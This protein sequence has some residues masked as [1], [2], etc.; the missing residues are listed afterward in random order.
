M[1]RIS[2]IVLIVC[3]V[4]AALYFFT[5]NYIVSSLAR[6]M[7]EKVEEKYGF[8]ITFSEVRMTGLAGVEV[9]Q[10][11]IHPP[12]GDTLLTIDSMYVRPSIP[13]I[14]L[15]RVKLTEVNIS[16]MLLHFSGHDSLVNYKPKKTTGPGEEETNTGG[17]T[18][19]AR[20]L[21]SLSRKVFS[22]SP[23]K[24]LLR[25]VNIRVDQDSIHENLLIPYYESDGDSL[26]GTLVDR[27]NDMTWKMNGT[28]SQ[29][30]ETFSIWIMP[31]ERKAT[32]FPLVRDLTGGY[33]TFDTLEFQLH[34]NEYGDG[35][36]R[37]SGY[38]QAKNLQVLHRRLSGD[39]IRIRNLQFDCHA[40]IGPHSLQL[41]SAT[42]LTLN[43]LPLNI[44][45]KLDKEM[46]PVV[47]LQL[48]THARPADDFFTS[49]PEGIFTE[50]QGV[51]ADGNLDFSLLYH[52]D[53][54]DPDKLVFDV[55]MKKEKFK[56]KKLG[57]NSLVKMNS[58][59]EHTVFEY[60]HPVKT[61]RVGPSDPGFV[62]IAEV[63]PFLKYAILTSEDGNFFYHNGFNEEAFR[64]SIAANFKAGRFVRGGSTISM[65]LVKNVYLSRNKTVARKVEEALLVWLIESNRLVTKERM[66]EVY[67]NII[68]LGPMV[69]GV[70]D[71][72][73]F[74]FNKTPSEVSLA[75]SIFLASLLPH[76]KWFKYSF[77]TTGAF[78]P[79]L[80]D[81]YRVVSNFML[82]KNLITEAEY[83]QLQ[84]H[85]ELRG[86]AKELVIPSETMP[87][88][89]SEENE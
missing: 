47:S 39:T 6:K 3:G 30:D 44:Y 28:F 45:A 22:M 68:E 84:P 23:Q 24:S 69:Y 18:N 50:V 83:N 20:M 2:R 64:N 72:C 32:G 31:G 14:F 11:V 89:S 8:L 25:Q 15:G 53:T 9:N 56:L 21:Y 19:Y 7:A 13:H 71:A 52:M 33:C 75:E 26:H 42:R 57:R 41:D 63:S 43:S 61:F 49:L 59:F 51:A 81:Y 16:D 60:G 35:L 80:A 5:R 78:K 38:M 70:K 58:D 87:A 37:A 10:L 66:F 76:P 27:M 85:V 62:S 40:T 65:Q 74:Y 29:A 54:A 55:R 79:Y 48:K 17:E 1:K 12:E 67:L 82:R 36:L 88:D 34:E 46:K 86:P 77:D 73:R 4:L